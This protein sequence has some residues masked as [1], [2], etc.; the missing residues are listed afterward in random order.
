MRTV[1]IIFGSSICCH[2]CNDVLP[3]SYCRHAIVT[4]GLRGCAL[5]GFGCIILLFNAPAV[6]LFPSLKTEKEKKW[7][8]ISPSCCPMLTD[9]ISYV[10]FLFYVFC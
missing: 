8:C 5:G 1:W 6:L 4:V 3:S 2:G 10:S 7:S 9:R